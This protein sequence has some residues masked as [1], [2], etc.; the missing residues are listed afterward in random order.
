MKT[1]QRTFSFQLSVVSVYDAVLNII[2]GLGPAFVKSI[3]SE[4]Y[5]VKNLADL[6]PEC[7]HEVDI[8]SPSH[9]NSCHLIVALVTLKGH[10]AN[11]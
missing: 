10:I 5:F 11:L 6:G 2:R 8:K 9:L 1:K 3:P 4:Y 7:C